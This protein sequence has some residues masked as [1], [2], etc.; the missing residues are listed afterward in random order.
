[1]ARTTIRTE[2]ITAGQVAMADLAA[3][4]NCDATTYLDGKLW[5]VIETGTD[6]KDLSAA[7][8]A[9]VAV[10]IQLIQQLRL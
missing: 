3:Y 8:F 10:T 4:S 2:D 7:N 9:D 1:M 6:G 5:S